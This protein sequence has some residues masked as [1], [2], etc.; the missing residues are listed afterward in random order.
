[1]SS[2]CDCGSCPEPNDGLARMQAGVPAP[3][4]ERP[5]GNW[6]HHS[7]QRPAVIRHY[8]GL[9]RY[10]NRC[11]VHGEAFLSERVGSVWDPVRWK[12]V[13]HHIPPTPLKR[14]SV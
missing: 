14:P 11:A 5:K 7:C 9:P 2:G 12:W 8:P 3:H 1:M 10:E 4:C 6:W 13:G